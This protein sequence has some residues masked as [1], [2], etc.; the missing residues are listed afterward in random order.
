MT[1]KLSDNYKTIIEN[2]ETAKKR[3]RLTNE[4]KV[5]AVTKTIEVDKINEAIDCG[6]N[7]LGENR[8]QEFLQKKDGYKKSEVHFIGGLQ[9]NKVRQ[10]ITDISLIQTVD[11]VK[12]AKEIDRQAK[13]NDLVMDILIQVNIGEEATKNGVTADELDELID[14]ISN[15]PNVQLRGL[16]A[17]PP[18]GDSERYFEKMQRLFEDLRQGNNKNNMDTLSMG[19]SGDYEVAVAYGATILRLGTAL[20]GKRS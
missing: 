20:F 18:F 6:I 3:S 7:L 4:I 17:I 15:F 14:D 1:G 16:M 9:T 5:M 12:L 10:I 8:V 13:L 2:I 19:M 11:S